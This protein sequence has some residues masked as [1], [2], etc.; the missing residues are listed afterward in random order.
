[1]SGYKVICNIC[2]LPDSQ[3]T[4][5]QLGVKMASR[6]VNIFVC[7][8]C[9]SPE[10]KK[11]IKEFIISKKAEIEKVKNKQKIGKYDEKNNYRNRN[12]H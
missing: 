7:R 12:N 11:A 6:R 2:G 1:M 9:I 3:I 10:V 8:R 5:T 4:S